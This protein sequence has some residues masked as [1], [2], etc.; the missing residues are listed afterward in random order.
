MLPV[1]PLFCLAT[2]CMYS[3][4]II[5]FAKTKPAEAS[6]QYNV[7]KKNVRGEASCSYLFGVFPLGNPDVA[8]QAMDRLGETAGGTGKS[9]GFVN[10]TG[11]ETIA[12]YFGL[13]LRRSLSIQADAVELPGR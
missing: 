12:N 7:V 2:G 3:R 11:D 13:F 5:G 9:V 4:G 6:D 1:L 10:F 8:T